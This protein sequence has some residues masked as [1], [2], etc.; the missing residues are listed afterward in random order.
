M[1]TPAKLNG[2]LRELDRLEADYED[3]LKLLDG[4]PT[5]LI[6]TRMALVETRRELGAVKIKATQQ[7]AGH[8]LRLQRYLQ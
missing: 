8:A 3:D 7:Q 6:S 1:T 5:D 2:A 4:I